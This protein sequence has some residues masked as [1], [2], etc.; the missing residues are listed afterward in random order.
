MLYLNGFSNQTQFVYP[1]LNYAGNFNATI[2]HNYYFGEDNAEV[3]PLRFTNGFSPDYFGFLNDGAPDNLGLRTSLL[4]DGYGLKYYT[5]TD[6]GSFLIDIG[7]APGGVSALTASTDCRRAPRLI[8]GNLSGGTA[9]PDIGAAEYTPFRLTG[10]PIPTSWRDLVADINANGS[11]TNPNYVEFDLDPGVFEVPVLTTTASVQNTVYIDGFT[12]DGS[13]IPG[14]N[15]NSL[16]SDSLTPARNLVIFRPQGNPNNGIELLSAPN[17]TI[18]G[19]SIVDFNEYGILIETGSNASTVFGNVIG[20]IPNVKHDLVGAENDSNGFGGILSK[21]EDIVIGGYFHHER[22]VLV[23][24]GQSAPIFGSNIHLIN[25]S[26]N[27]TIIGNVIGLHPNGKDTIPLSGTGTNKPHG[28]YIE[29]ADNIQIGSDQFFG[30][31]T[32]ANHRGSGIVHNSANGGCSID[33]NHIGTNFIGDEPLGNENGIFINN[34]NGY[35]VGTNAGNLIS[36]NDSTGIKI[37]D[38][39]AIRVVGNNIGGD[40]LAAANN[41]G[42]VVAGIFIEGLSGSAANPNYVGVDDYQDA[43]KRNVIVNNGVGI[44]LTGPDVEETNIKGNLIGVGSHTA[45][46]ALG[47][48][49]G[50]KIDNGAHDNFIGFEYVNASSPVNEINIISGNITTGILIE[51]A[52]TNS[53]RIASNIVGGT[54]PLVAGD[55]LQAVGNLNG[56]RLA[57][58]AVSNFNIIGSEDDQVRKLVIV[59][60][61]IGVR[62]DSSAESIIFNSLIGIDTNDNII[63][64]NFGILTDLSETGAFGGSGNKSNIV[65][66]NDSIG[67]FL[68]D[69]KDITVAGNFIGTEKTGLIA[70]PNEVGIRIKGGGGH[71]IGDAQANL[72]SGN[73]FGLILQDS[74]EGN[75]IRN[76]YFGLTKDGLATVP[77]SYFGIITNNLVTANNIGSQTAGSTNYFATDTADITIRSSKDQ[78]VVNNIMGYGIDETTILGATKKGIGIHL[79]NS[80]LIRIGDASAIGRNSVANKI[81]GIL[82]N[83]ADSCHIQNTYFGT[84]P[85]GQTVNVVDNQRYGIVNRA[86]TSVENKIGPNNVF[87]GNDIGIAIG[88]SS[89]NN[90]IYSNYFGTNITETNSFRNDT[91]IIFSNASSNTVGFSGSP[92]YFVNYRAGIVLKNNADTNV[93]KSNF[94]G[95][96]SAGVAGTNTSNGVLIDNSFRNVFGSSLLTEANTISNNNGSGISVINNSEGNSFFRNSIHSNGGLGIDIGGNNT[97]DNNG[98][99]TIQNGMETPIIRSTFPCTSGGNVNV[100]LI[101]NGLT[102]GEQYYVDL[103]NSNGYIDPQDYGEG[104][105][106]IHFA[107]HTAGNVSD[108][109]TYDLTALGVP[110]ALSDTLVAILTSASNGSSSEFGKWN[111]V[112]DAPSNPTIGR[113]HFPCVGALAGGLVRVDNSINSSFHYEVFLNGTIMTPE[114]SPNQ[115]EWVTDSLPFGVQNVVINYSNGCSQSYNT[116]INN[117]NQ[118]FDVDATVVSDTCGLGTGELVLGVI[119]NSIVSG[120]LDTLY[121]FDNGV[122]YGQNLSLTGLIAGMSYNVTAI[123]NVFGNQCPASDTI[124]ITISSYTIP[125]SDLAFSY[126]DFCADQTGVVT[127]LPIYSNGTYSLSGP[128]VAFS[129]SNGNIGGATAGDVFDL[130]YIYGS[131]ESTTVQATA[132]AVPN[133]SFTLDDFCANGTANSGVPVT[134]GGTFSLLSLPVSA[135]E[136]INA[137]TGQLQTTF[138]EFTLGNYEVNYLT[139]D[140]NCPRNS[141]VFVEVFGKATDVSFTTGGSVFADTIDF[142]PNLLASTITNTN[143]TH[144]STVWIEPDGNTISNTIYTVNLSNADSLYKL[145]YY[146]TVN[147]GAS[148]SPANLE[149]ESDNDS[150]WVRIYALPVQPNLTSGDTAYCFGETFPP[151]ENIATNIATSWYSDAGITL[152]ASDTNRYTPP[153]LNNNSIQTVYARDFTGLGCFS[154]LISTEVA[155]LIKPIRPRIEYLGATYPNNDS[156]EVCPNP[157]GD[158]L[159]SFHNATVP[160]DQDSTYWGTIGSPISHTVNA[161]ELNAVPNTYELYYLKDSLFSVGSSI[162]DKACFSDTGFVKV[163]MREIPFKPDIFNDSIAYCFGE[164][165]D[166][167][168]NDSLLQTHNVLWYENDKMDMSFLS[169]PSDSHFVMSPVYDDNPFYVYARDSTG[170]NCYSEYDSIKM[171]FHQLPDLP[172]LQIN[173]ILN[174]VLVSQSIVK[175]C[176]NPGEMD[177]IIASTGSYTNTNTIW[178]IVGGITDTLEYFNITTLA[179]MTDTLVYSRDTLYAESDK[180]CNTARDT[181]YLEVL[182]LPIATSFSDTAY[183]ENENIANLVTN[184]GENLLWKSN[185][186]STVTTTPTH[187]YL[188]IAPGSYNYQIDTITVRDSSGVTSL[189]I[190]CLSTIDTIRIAYHGRPDTAIVNLLSSGMQSFDT[191]FICPGT[192]ESFEVDPASV[193]ISQSY[194]YSQNGSDIISTTFNLDGFGPNSDST[195]YNFRDTTVTLTTEKTCYSDTNSRIVHTYEAPTPPILNISDTAYC[196]GEL[197][198]IL[199]VTNAVTQIIWSENGSGA[200]TSIA[201]HQYSQTVP[202]VYGYQIDTVIFRN[203]TGTNNFGAECSSA[204]DTVRIAY[205][206]KVDTATVNLLSSGMQSFDTTFICPGTTESFEVDPASVTASQSHW[207][208]Q[209]GVQAIGTTFNLDGFGPNSDSTIYNFRDTT[210]TL[211]IE[212]TCYSDTNSRVVHTFTAPTLPILNISDTAYCEG[213]LVEI[214][215]VTNAVTQIIWSENGS[216]ATTSI[217]PHQYSQT[218]P[219]IYSN[220][221]DTVIFRNFTGTNNFGQECT[222]DE[223]TVT[224]DYKATPPTPEIDANDFDYC[225]G[226]AIEPMYEVNLNNTNWYLFDGTNSTLIATDTDT[227][228]PAS[229]GGYFA[230]TVINDCPSLFSD[231]TLQILILLRPATPVI[232]PMKTEYCSGDIIDTIKIESDAK[233]IWYANSDFNNSIAF[234]KDF[235]LESNPIVDSVEY[236]VHISDDQ[237]CF[238]LYDSIT[239]IQYVSKGSIVSDELVEICAGFFATLKV[240]GGAS[241]LWSTSDTTTSVTVSPTTTTLYTVEIIDSN[242]CL[243]TD[244]I[245]VSLKLPANC[246][247]EVY[248][249]FSPNGDGVNETWTITGLEN[250]DKVSVYIFNRWGDQI[251][252]IDEYDNNTN[253]WDG[254]NQN[255]NSFVESGTYYYILEEANGNKIKDGWVQLMK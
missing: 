152:V 129:P 35:S 59:G 124:P 97:V 187:V 179:G 127:T 150:L 189:G 185:F 253:A 72:I 211:T 239:L 162:M 27:T 231:D 245:E 242:N 45:S 149:C 190:E 123:I 151:L 20:A 56:V 24:N 94:I 15:H 188:P 238:S 91:A 195:I 52:T 125:N 37:K 33:N 171:R 227:I 220:Q 145:N 74:T 217:A 108:T 48:T 197:V 169:V 229:T 223:D 131:C 146:G 83:T 232:A 214:L 114:P 201:P 204:E 67:V 87:G 6:G 147:Y 243:T 128:T 246:N 167:L 153:I 39:E 247:E 54:I 109:V 30:Q 61:E 176:P 126:N 98:I 191:T 65:S 208:S 183:C 85:T 234:Q 43:A 142:C 106:S 36:A 213:E 77:G 40:K 53:N 18:A 159:F 137:S 119:N 157:M 184:T 198:E 10:S 132:L 90:S 200:T 172:T 28:I 166:T 51:G 144:N 154:S 102:P 75:T 95:A 23:D 163:K 141:S 71:K 192:T 120:N 41:M 225:E 205:H 255:T 233:G 88:A 89:N 103:Y 50:V 248:T 84:E 4:T 86:G 60:N 193:L 202:P 104:K 177:S 174:P 140:A 133:Q 14:P 186:A 143:G 237:G 113:R 32:I 49:I 100:E 148:S 210:I 135:P 216:G 121:S 111:F 63:P 8:D 139:N 34:A 68:R 252:R 42:N 55:P 249:A 207:Y 138:S 219:T 122:T 66:G 70:R 101:L 25:S 215:E 3:L 57:N 17:S 69:S 117:S 222:S 82:M 182:P 115:N 26:N 16:S 180:Y 196:E 156:I 134:G 221:I 2:S 5:I 130:K 155:F 250:Y 170:T 212:K 161:Y 244:S 209:T 62:I 175:F 173:H 199:E 203:F 44:Y 181:V 13:S 31:N 254:L 81:A 110:A 9:T 107:T 112:S 38:G 96:S 235:Y 47:N 116:T 58:I 241:Y 105:T 206:G 194:W 92:N 7:T 80:K 64:N 79:L 158:T 251:A 12:F 218:V 78:V 11:T 1:F 19:L 178:E 76:N 21:A 22:N 160:T 224:I 236:F 99:A 136:T 168:R 93:F 230:Q 228:F 29:G 226:F 240:D 165:I 46:S 73:Y 164:V 118:T